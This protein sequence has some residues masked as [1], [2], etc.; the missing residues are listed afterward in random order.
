MELED[1]M[2]D[3]CYYSAVWG[4]R[5]ATRRRSG[6]TSSV[7]FFLM[8]PFFDKVGS[9]D[10]PLS[11][12]TSASPKA[13]YWAFGLKRRQIAGFGTLRPHF[14]GTLDVEGQCCRSGGSAL[15]LQLTVM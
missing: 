10:G 7:P 3:C 14:G 12:W 11:L 2:L 1:S 15:F 8:G 6:R 5:T 13:S 9:P 4:W